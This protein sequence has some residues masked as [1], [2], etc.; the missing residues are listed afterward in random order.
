MSN[1]VC[2]R[3]GCIVPPPRVTTWNL[4]VLF[5]S[6]TTLMRSRLHLA[7]QLMADADI[8]GVQEVHVGAT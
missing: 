6:D 8:L 2:L 5:A 1:V 4:S 3:L 7:K